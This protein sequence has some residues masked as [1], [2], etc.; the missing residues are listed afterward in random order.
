MTTLEH[1]SDS[2]P[3]RTSAPGVSSDHQIRIM[4][5]RMNEWPVD[6]GQSIL[7]RVIVLVVG[8]LF[9]H[10]WNQYPDAIR[11]L[12]GHLATGL[13]W[14]GVAFLLFGLMAVLFGFHFK[15]KG[16]GRPRLSWFFRNSH[17][18]DRPESP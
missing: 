7:R 8:L 18:P 12:G 11:I 4:R 17:T 14:F 13:L 15:R 2:S 9:F 10:V 6:T 1:S 16:K 3:D 5:A